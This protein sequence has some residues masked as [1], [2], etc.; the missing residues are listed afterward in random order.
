VPDLDFEI[1]GV[2]PCT[3]NVTPT[4]EFKLRISNVPEV[5][6]IQAVLLNCQIQIQSAQRSYSAGEKEKLIEVFG[7]PESWGQTLRNR[8]WVHATATVGAFTGS[9][10]ATLPVPCTCDLN[11]WSTK[12]FEALD[13]GEVSLLFLFSG[14][15]FYAGPGG[16]L[17]VMPISWNKECAFRMPAAQWQNLM[18]QS[19]PNTRWVPLQLEIFEAL[20]AYKRNQALMSWESV[21]ERLLEE[22]SATGQSVAA[23]RARQEV[24][25]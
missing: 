2:A 13:G 11:L 17:Q 24:P 23:T 1:S 19:Y 16:Q 14:S 3:R 20:S 10:E 4:L 9:T 25:A 5:E 12:Y 7:L 8:L 21:I 18:E 22:P 6:A 15:M